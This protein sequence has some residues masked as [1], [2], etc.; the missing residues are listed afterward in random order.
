[1][2]SGAATASDPAHVRRPAG[3]GHAA[4]DAHRS[5]VWRQ[6]RAGMARARVDVVCRE[7]NRC[8]DASGRPRGAT[9]RLC[10]GPPLH[11]HA[12][13]RARRDRPG[14]PPA[15]PRGL[16]ATTASAPHGGQAPGP[17]ACGASTGRLIADALCPPD[18]RRSGTVSRDRT[19]MRCRAAD[20]GWPVSQW[21]HQETLDP[22]GWLTEDE[23]TRK[24]LELSRTMWAVEHELQE[25][26]AEGRAI[27]PAAVERMCRR[28]ARRAR[29]AGGARTPLA[30]P[31]GST[32]RGVV[33]H[34]HRLG[35]KARLHRRRCRALRD[36]AA[37]ARRRVPRPA[38][39][40]ADHDR[41]GRLP[42]RC[43]SGAGGA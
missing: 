33:L 16:M 36:H 3:W 8:R 14:R 15:R 21:C 11:G 32:R 40:L 13:A 20:L 2:W 25:P 39:A 5:A 42:P 29:L 34:R 1:M 22:H 17:H 38:T 12:T 19:A 31:A 7:G 28:H 27:D 30:R 9:G 43:V 24:R 6:L 4:S 18:P 35:P 23:V 10:G 41:A 26:S 37:P